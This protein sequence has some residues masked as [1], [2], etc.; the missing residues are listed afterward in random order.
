M[1]ST[2]IAMK[3]TAQRGAIG[4]HMKLRTPLSPARTIADQVRPGLAHDDEDSDRDEG[5]TQQQVNPTPGRC[6][7]CVDV[8]VNLDEECVVDE[9]GNAVEGPGQSGHHQHRRREDGDSHRHRI[10]PR[11]ATEIYHHHTPVRV[12]PH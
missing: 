12:K 9:R 3:R 2:S 6:V 4:S 8:P 11:L 7:K 5:R 1:I 10:A